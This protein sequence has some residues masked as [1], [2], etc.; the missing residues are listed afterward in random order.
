M[1]KNI[2]KKKRKITGA[3]K[4]E[5]VW[6]KEKEKKMKIIKMKIKMKNNSTVRGWCRFGDEIR[7]TWSK[8]KKKKTTDQEQSETHLVKRVMWNSYSDEW[9]KEKRLC[10]ISKLCKLCKL[11]W[12]KVR[13]Y[14]F[15]LA[16]AL[17]WTSWHFPDEM[18]F[19]FKDHASQLFQTEMIV[20]ITILISYNLFGNLFF[21]NQRNLGMPESGI[22]ME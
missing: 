14:C 20:S 12:N 5:G 22:A 16:S 9:D 15:P 4:R 19:L 3:I 8:L 17:R 7:S 11:S 21:H 10:F 13:N 18:G 1:F 6:M 2:K